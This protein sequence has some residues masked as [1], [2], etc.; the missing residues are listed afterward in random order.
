V[1]SILT[2][3]A[4]FLTAAVVMVPIAKRLK[5]GAV[6]GYL[7]AGIAIGPWGAR[8]ILEGETILHF[9]EFGVVLLLFVI[10][11][12]LNPR[13]LWALRRSIIGFGASQV[14]LTTALLFV[15]GLA[16]GV[17]LKIALLGAMVLSLSSTAFALQLID[18]RRMTRTQA[19]QIGFSTLLFQDIAVIPMLAII[20]LLGVTTNTVAQDSILVD[21]LQAIATIGLVVV[22]GAWIVKPMFR[23]I[24]KTELRE[25][26][27]AFSL[28]LVIGTALLM[29]AAGM[30]MALGAFIGGVVLAESEYRHEVEIDVEPF[31]GLLMG[32][33][34]IA[35]GMM[36]DVGLLLS[37]PLTIIGL[38]LLLIAIKF[39]TILVL[40]RIT[41]VTGHQ[42]WRLAALLCQGGEFGFVLFVAAA[43]YNVIP[44]SLADILIVVIVTSMMV[45]PLVL[46]GAERIVAWRFGEVKEVETDDFDDPTHP[47]II[48]GFGRYGQVVDRLL[49]ANRIPTTVIDRDP[50][51]IELLRQFGHQVFY[52]DATRL[53][54]LRAAGIDT[55]RLLIVALDDPEATVEL[56]DL[57]QQHYP[58]LPLIVRVRN[59]TQA[60]EMMDRGVEHIE[61]ET[62]AAALNTGVRALKAL[63][64]DDRMASDAARVFHEHD[65]TTLRELYPIHRDQEKLISLVAQARADLEQLMD[66]EHRREAS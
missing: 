64:L 1:E 12:E 32:L 10:G 15:A 44:Q 11:L 28:L 20:P 37:Q 48:A 8:L 4:I 14:L 6:I 27:T 52:G 60:Y 17:G 5:M 57:V 59:R 22:I 13:R 26:F 49:H 58:E 24:A 40:A 31:K 66:A 38:T 42:S 16:L 34:F 35:V 2:K 39:G 9:A 30:S 45:T 46:F 50:D 3:A 61:R 43:I 41:K 18:E 7:I 29:E 65:E 55:A 25:I 56:V 19:G 36:M 54:L 51:Q 53:Q 47:V 62:F 23:V 63:G 21:A 33:F